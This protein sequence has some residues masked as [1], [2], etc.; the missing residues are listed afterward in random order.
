MDRQIV[1]PGSIPLDTDLLS[2]QRNS[3]VAVGYLAQATLGTNTLVDG[4]ACNP[5]APASLTVTIGPG[6]I[7]SLSVI[8]AQPFG[9]LP[10]ES[11][12]PLVKMGI[13]TG[14]TSFTLTAPG[15]SGQSIN[16][17]VQASLS[18]VDSTPVVLPYYNAAN[19]TQ[20][21]TGPSGNGASQDTQRLCQVQL[22]LKPSPP[23]NA[24]AQV[25]PAVDQGWTGLYVITVNYGQTQIVASDIAVLPGAPFIAFKL[26][27]STPGFSRMTSFTSSG[28]FTVPNGTS[29]VKVR[30]CGGGGGGGAGAPGFGGSGGGGGGYAE[31]IFA[32]QPGQVIPVTVGS[33][34]TAGISGGAAAGQGGTTSF[35][36]M[37]AATGGLGGAPGAG[38]APGAAPGAG[39]G[40]A[41]NANGGYG[42]DGNGAGFVFAGNG[43]SSAFGGGGRAATNGSSPQQNGQAPGS[44]A[45]GCYGIAQNGGIGAAGLV[46]VEY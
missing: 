6:S 30:L 27:A 21:F 24:G 33:A 14:P 37:M 7:I 10:A 5:T 38:S 40:G 31:G 1:Y 44:G 13:S 34:G 18:E 36:T 42:S 46:I 29:L 32:V 12:L 16:Y 20:P 41:I 28:S 3:M 39:T 15:T 26:G 17:L 2:I 43:G 8:D 25:T 19:P 35:G 45:G 23:A 4:L 11:G 9:S 22:Q